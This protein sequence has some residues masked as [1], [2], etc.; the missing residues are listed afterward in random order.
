MKGYMDFVVE[1]AKGRYSNKLD[2]DGNE[3]ILT[4]NYKTIPMYL[5]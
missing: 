1:P 3:F 4:L 2:I 5:E